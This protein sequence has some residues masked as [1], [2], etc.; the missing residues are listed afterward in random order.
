MQVDKYAIT[1]LNLIFRSFTKMC[2]LNRT[3]I[4]GVS[5]WKSPIENPKLGNSM[6]EILIRPLWGIPENPV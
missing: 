4:T 5:V 6:K 3:T 1:L 2:L